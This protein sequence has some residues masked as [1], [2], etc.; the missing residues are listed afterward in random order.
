MK[1][2]YSRKSGLSSLDRKNYYY[3]L[4]NIESWLSKENILNFVSKA[5]IAEEENILSGKYDISIKYSFVKDIR[6]TYLPVFLSYFAR[7]NKYYSSK[8]RVKM[9]NLYRQGSHSII[10]KFQCGYISGLTK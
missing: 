7:K 8:H 9:T 4:K 5:E 6:D 10:A 3:I 1:Y 2:C